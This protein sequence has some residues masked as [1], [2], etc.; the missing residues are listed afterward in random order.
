LRN[1]RIVFEELQAL[2][3]DLMVAN[4]VLLGEE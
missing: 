4:A 3:W 1:Y 2:I